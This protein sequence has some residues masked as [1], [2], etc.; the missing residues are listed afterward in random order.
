[1]KD[2]P[3]GCEFQAGGALEMPNPTSPL[4]RPLAWTE[5]PDQWAKSQTRHV[6]SLRQLGARVA[7]TSGRTKGDLPWLK[8]ADFGDDRTDRGSLRSN[9]NMLAING[10]ELDYDD[11]DLTWDQAWARLYEARLPAL[12]YTTR[13]HTS[14]RHRFRV[15]LPTSC[16]LPPEHRARLVARAYGVLRG[17]VDRA[18]FTPSQSFYFGSVERGCVF[19]E[20]PNPPGGRFIDLA[21]D[22]DEGA[23]DKRGQPWSEEKQLADDAE[24]LADADDD[25]FSDVHPEPDI[26]RIGAALANIPADE[27]EVWLTVGMALHHEFDGEDEGFA[28]W[29]EWSQA[30]HKYDESVQRDTWETFGSYVGKPLTIATL[31]K[32]AKESENA[33]RKFGDLLF[34]TTEECRLTPPQKYVVKRLIASG[35]VVCIFGAPGTGKSL[36]GPFIAYQVALGEPAFGLRTKQGLAFYVAAEDP[37]GMKNRIAALAIRQGHASH[38]RLVNGVSDLFA[39]DSPDL[40]ALTGAIE[41]ERPALIVIDTLAM[42]FPG[43]EENESKS[44]ARVVSVARQLASFG[45]AVVLIHH[46]TKAEGSTPRGHSRL[47]GD[48]DMAIHVKRNGDGIVRGRLTKNRNGSADLAIAFKIGVEELGEDEDGDAVTAAI[49]EE[50]SGSEAGR[51]T[52]LP[53]AQQAALA[54]LEKLEANGAVTN[55][56]WAKVCSEGS[57]VSQSEN[58]KSRRDCFS[59]ARRELVNSGLVEID[60]NQNVRS[61]FL[62][63]DETLFDDDDEL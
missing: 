45:S 37:H 34:I 40:K 23:L 63:Y 24:G 20:M 42:A 25:E 33:S 6:S 43:L 31:Y 29:D 28:M 26:D 7:R 19:I 9:A 27:R 17:S 11:G 4:D 60:A 50:L 47:N 1:M 22:L 61:K 5:F 59:R 49:V 13:R 39:D 10:I 62:A 51:P 41:K 2:Q 38:F 58:A 21:D 54:I 36:L 57:L 14:D 30:S 8:L 48:L 35:N 46:D 12:L 3:V 18:S 16:P 55:A 52:K 44:M 53:A 32:L 56:Q 15:L